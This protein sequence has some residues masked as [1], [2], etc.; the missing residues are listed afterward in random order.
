M[1]LPTERLVNR[2]RQ[3]GFK[4]KREADRVHAYKK[5]MR[6]VFVPRSA[7]VVE[8]AAATILRQAGVSEPEIESFL[9]DCRA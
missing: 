5:G 7:T 2:L 8:E 6:Y 4:H 9:R 1:R 3:E